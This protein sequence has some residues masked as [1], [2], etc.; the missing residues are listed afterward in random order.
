MAG[1]R[2][3]SLVFGVL[4]SGLCGPPG[5]ASQSTKGHEHGVRVF[6]LGVRAVLGRAASG[7]KCRLTQGQAAPRAELSQ[8]RRK[9]PR[10]TPG[11]PHRLPLRACRNSAPLVGICAARLVPGLVKPHPRGKTRAQGSRISRANERDQIMAT[12]TAQKNASNTMLRSQPSRQAITLELVAAHT[13]SHALVGRLCS[14]FGL[15]PVDY[16]GIREATKEQLSLSAE[17]LQPTVNETAMKIHLQ[18]VVGSFVSSAHGAAQ[19]Y[20]GKV[21][22]ARDLTSKLANDDRDEDREG[23]YGFESRAARARQFA[24]EAGLTAYALMAAAEGAV[25]AYIHIT[26][27]T[28]KPYEPPVAGP[29]TVGRQ[30]AE[31]EIAAFG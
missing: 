18:R 10:Y 16:D 1:G 21:T 19:F 30:A 3:Q 2:A 29:A 8:R 4:P 20:G 22:Q 5:S 14:T 6:P 28:W 7:S 15:D 31:A 11:G 17:T 26:G 25:A 24:A 27:E 13:P 23:V 12:K 9:A